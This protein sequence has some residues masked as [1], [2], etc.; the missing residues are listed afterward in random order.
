MDFE[1][2][3]DQ[4]AIA[5]MAGSLMSDYCT[6]E[7]LRDWDLSGQAYM[8][9]LWSGC[10]ETGLHALAI[11]EAAGGSGLGMTELMQILDAQGGALAQVPLWRHQL[12]AATLAEFGGAPLTPWVEQAVTATG[13]LTLSLDGL[14]NV[15]GIE[16]QASAEA[17]GWR[18]AGRVAALAL[19]E[20]SV[21]ALLLALV[22]G[23]PR[24]VL[25]DLGQTGISK[26]PG[27]MTHG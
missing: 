16:L 3:E 27:V 19:A 18:L 24:L 1:L 9:E 22:S 11:P 6:D 25:V 15:R 20:Q 7:R 5:E 13:L 4:R 10:V 8:H 21:A 17:D 23:Q 26:V 2:N 12:A 14:S